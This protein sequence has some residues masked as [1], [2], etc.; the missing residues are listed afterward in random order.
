M[1]TT[2]MIDEIT[3]VEIDGAMVQYFEKMNGRWVGLGPAERWSE[4]LIK[5]EFE[6]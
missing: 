5:E 6:V 3:K 4:E 2:I 1:R